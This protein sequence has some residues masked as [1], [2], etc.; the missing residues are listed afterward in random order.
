M[1]F[2]RWILLLPFALGFSWVLQVAVATMALFLGEPLRGLVLAGSGIV[3]GA[4]SVGLAAA[5][6]PVMKEGVASLMLILISALAFYAATLSH[7]VWPDWALTGFAVA[8]ALSGAGM[9]WWVRACEDIERD[10]A[11]LVCSPCLM[12]LHFGGFVIFL[13]SCYIAFGHGVIPFLLTM[14]MPF[15]A[16]IYWFFVVF[17][18]EGVANL[19]CVAVLVWIVAAVLSV[20]G[21]GVLALCEQRA[22]ETGPRC[23]E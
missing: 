1:N 12:Y 10:M 4:V 20:L 7:P 22:K 11:M 15:I 17:S 8:T 3:M 2:L 16:Q 6:A 9:G 21:A 13:M 18:H 19:Y 5:I 14:T 23:G